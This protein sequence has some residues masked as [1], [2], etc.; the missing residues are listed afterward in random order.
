MRCASL[1]LKHGRATSLAQRR[2]LITSNKAESVPAVMPK[3]FAVEPTTGELGSIMRLGAGDAYITLNVGGK[4]FHTLRSTVNSNRVLA[5]HVAR[6]EANHEITKSG[7]VFIDR[8]P[9]HFDFILQY[10]RNRITVSTS[11]CKLSGWE[12]KPKS[13]V[14]LPDDPKVRRELYLEASYYQ[15]TELS[16]YI[17]SS[18]WLTNI[19]SVFNHNANPFDAASRIAVQVRAA[20]LTFGTVGGTMAVTMQEE[21]DYVLERIGLKRKEEEEVATS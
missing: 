5:E 9:D 1:L 11:G 18:N 13:L 10:L 20:L 14:H 7:A 19:V 4:D 8:N 6:A 15:I 2:L 17:S 21:F 16:K 3:D 12:L